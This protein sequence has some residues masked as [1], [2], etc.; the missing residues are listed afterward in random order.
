MRGNPSLEYRTK[1]F[2]KPMNI[3]QILTIISTNEQP[4]SNRLISVNYE[5]MT[6]LSFILIYQYH[7]PKDALAPQYFDLGELSEITLTFTSLTWKPQ[8][9][10]IT[11]ADIYQLIQLLTYYCGNNER[12]YIIQTSCAQQR[13]IIDRSDTSL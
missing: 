6:H 3:C 2:K 10:L 13:V 9:Y 12:V 4:Y 7:Y 5:S 1:L 8:Y 11:I